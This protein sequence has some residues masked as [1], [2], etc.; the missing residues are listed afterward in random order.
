MKS[1]GKKRQRQTKTTEKQRRTTCRNTKHDFLGA[2]T[3]I[4]HRRKIVGEE[5]NIRQRK[6]KEDERHRRNKDKSL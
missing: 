1:K 2:H 6:T 3:F 4:D 5:E